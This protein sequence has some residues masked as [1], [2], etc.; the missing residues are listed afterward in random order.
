MQTTL[1]TSNIGLIV[2]IGLGIAVIV[3]IALIRSYKTTVFHDIKR[4]ISLVLMLMLALAMPIIT[5]V[6]FLVKP[7]GISDQDIST[8]SISFLTMI[9]G[10]VI[11]IAMKLLWVVEDRKEHQEVKDH[12]SSD[13]IMDQLRL[14]KKEITLLQT[15][16]PDAARLADVISTSFDGKA[17]PL[18]VNIYLF[19][20]EASAGSQRFME[21]NVENLNGNEYDEK[22]SNSGFACQV[23]S[24]LDNFIQRFE[25]TNHIHIR[26]YLHTKMPK[27]K[28][29]L[30][31]EDI[32]YSSYPAGKGSTS[33]N[34]SLLN[35]KDMTDP[36]KK[37]IVSD[38][39]DVLLEIKKL[40][41]TKLYYEKK[42]QEKGQFY[43]GRYF[44]ESACL[45]RET[46]SKD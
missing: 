44:L 11:V 33:S 4:N 14:A 42:V 45:H 25:K 5:I 18:N 29:Y 21:I 8:M 39:K 36:K 17:R 9:M 23:I 10:T 20:P 31:D 6:K 41:T 27:Q 28:I 16:F 34:P 3:F 1:E 19:N 7:I 2:P 40:P 35:K 26:I 30:I 12:W 43:G 24:S 13:V 22:I 32:L 37:S 15:W 38:C 46:V